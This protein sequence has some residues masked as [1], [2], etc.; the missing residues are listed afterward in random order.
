VRDCIFRKQVSPLL[1]GS[2]VPVPHD[3]QGR[4]FARTPLP[5]IRLWVEAAVC[6]WT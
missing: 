6:M 5:R 3:V 4:R 1:L 2:R